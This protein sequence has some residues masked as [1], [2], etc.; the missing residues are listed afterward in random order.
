[1]PPPSVSPPIP[2]EA[3]SPKGDGEPC[4]RGGGRDLARGEAAARARD[5]LAGVDLEPAAGAPDRARSRP[6]SCRGRRAVAAAADGELEAASPARARRRRRPRRRRRAAR[7]P[8]DGG[9]SPAGRRAAPRRSRRRRGR[10]RRRRARRAAL[11]M[12][13]RDCEI[14]FMCDSS[15]LAC[16]GPA[17]ASRRRGRRAPYGAQAFG[18]AVLRTPHPRYEPRKRQHREHAPV[19]LGRG[20]QAELREDARHVLLDG[21]RR[22]E[23][24]LA[25]RVVGTSL[26]HQLEHLALAGREPLDRVVARDCARRARR[27]RAGRA[28]S[29]LRRRGG[30][31]P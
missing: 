17:Q 13:T 10:R 23:E 20:R 21:T 29:R 30:R 2:T 9:R 27:R 8:P 11:E 14:V 3:V 18:G 25:D 1:M 12:E 7:S 24:P 22:D 5:P 31:R 16:F 26:G 6:R 4:A 15:R 19:V 28:P